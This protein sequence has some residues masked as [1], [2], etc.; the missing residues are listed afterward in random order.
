MRSRV[1]LCKVLTNICSAEEPGTPCSQ[2]AKN[3]WVRPGSSGSPQTLG[4]SVLPSP[5][6][7]AAA[8]LLTRWK[9]TVTNGYLNNFT[10]LASVRVCVS[11]TEFGLEIDGAFPSCTWGSERPPEAFVGEQRP[12]LLGLVSWT[13]HAEVIWHKGAIKSHHYISWQKK[14]TGNFPNAIS[15]ST[16]RGRWGG[17]GVGRE[18]KSFSTRIYQVSQPCSLV[19]SLRC[20]GNDRAHRLSS[21]AGPS[22][23]PYRSIWL[24]SFPLLS[25]LQPHSPPLTPQK[26]VLMSSTCTPFALSSRPSNA[27]SSFGSQLKSVPRHSH[28]L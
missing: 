9:K 8:D 13:H 14:M 10:A 27:T 22:R 20:K 3:G 23:P 6:S 17:K 11:E 18:E 5:L 16:E 12:C 15:L 1:F 7:D 19:A 4:G 24:T 21:E 25:G 26:Q 2:Q 28:L